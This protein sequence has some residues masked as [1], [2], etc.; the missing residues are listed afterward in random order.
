MNGQFENMT[1]TVVTGLLGLV[2]AVL[3]L[4]FGGHELTSWQ[5]FGGLLAGVVCAI[6]FGPLLLMLWTDCP[7]QVL[8]AV[9]LVIGL[10][11]LFIIRGLLAA[12]K[13][14]ETNIPVLIG[15][16]IRSRTGADYRDQSPPLPPGEL[17]K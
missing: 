15:K 11:S 10:G 16:A 13:T 1:D 3:S 5:R 9:S 6:A 2:G 14:F 4:L 12:W 17:P 8:S 7:A